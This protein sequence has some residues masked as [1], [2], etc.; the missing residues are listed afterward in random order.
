MNGRLGRSII[1]AGEYSIDDIA[2]SWVER[3][4]GIASIAEIPNGRAWFA[5]ISRAAGRSA[6]H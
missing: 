6:R 4:N 1:L 3:R 2:L 5:A